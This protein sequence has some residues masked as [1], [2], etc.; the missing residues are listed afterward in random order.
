MHLPALWEEKDVTLV[1]VPNKQDL[2]AAAGLNVSTGAFA[3]VQEGEAKALL[4]KI[5]NTLGKKD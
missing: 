3:I 1:V 5:N 4:K 2:G